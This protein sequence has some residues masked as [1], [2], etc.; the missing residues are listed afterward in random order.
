LG[1]PRQSAIGHETRDA[2]VPS[3]VIT[4]VALAVATAVVSVIGYLIF[5]YL[6]SRP[7]TTALPNPMVG[8]TR[9]PPPGPRLE[10]HPQ[11]ELEQLRALENQTLSTYGWVDKQ[12]GIVRIPLDRAMELQLQRGFPVRK[13]P[14][15]EPRQ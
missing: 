15:T 10:E 8:A 1:A 7:L 4:G 6:E 2:R 9:Q 14:A 12:E 3:V 5:I 13:M 11:I